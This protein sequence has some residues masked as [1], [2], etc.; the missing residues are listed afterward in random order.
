M[1]APPGRR[2][3]RLR[4]PC[5][6]PVGSPLA[7][8]PGRPPLSRATEPA[9]R[10]RGVGPWL[11][12]APVAWSLLVAGCGKGVNPPFGRSSGGREGRSG[13]WPFR[14][15]RTHPRHNSLSLPALRHSL[16]RNQANEANKP[17]RM[18]QYTRSDPSP[19]AVHSLLQT[20]SVR[21]PKAR[22]LPHRYGDRWDRRRNC[23]RGPR[24]PGHQADRRCGGGLVLRLRR[25]G[26]DGTPDIDPARLVT[27]S[28][29][30]KGRR[31][32]GGDMNY[33]TYWLRNL[34]ERRSLAEHQR[35]AREV[36]H[37]GR[38]RHRWSR[39]PASRTETNSTST[40]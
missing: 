14:C 29:G 39:Q 18:I 16:Y 11:P 27:P 20:G 30:G 10:G 28:A 12:P 35:V 24:W 6:G 4:V 37:A 40:T 9:G 23:L 8:P 1:C 13:G 15:R 38:R 32:G 21:K 34:V 25:P 5:R 31:Y 33:L 17:Q 3:P 26:R 36:A 2:S 7:R 22:R 19:M